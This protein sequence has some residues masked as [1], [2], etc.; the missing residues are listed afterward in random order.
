[1]TEGHCAEPAS[2]HKHANRP[3]ITALVLT[4]IPLQPRRKLSL[5]GGSAA[6]V[7]EP[8][9]QKTNLKQQGGASSSPPARQARFSGIR[10]CRGRLF[11]G[12]FLLAKQKKVTSCRATPGQWSVVLQ[13]TQLQHTG[14]T[15]GIAPRIHPQYILYGKN[16]PFKTIFT[17]SP[18]GSGTREISIEKSIA[19]MMPSPNSSWISDLIV[20]PYTM[21]SS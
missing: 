20:M 9:L 7:F 16:F 8:R 12:Y 5:P 14:R 19:L 11:F 1:M 13:R 17:R 4:F 21:I 6:K 10:G 18:L 15:R 2:H 3:V